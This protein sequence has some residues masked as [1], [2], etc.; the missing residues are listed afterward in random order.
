[1][2]TLRQTKLFCLS[3]SDNYCIRSILEI[4]CTVLYKR[5]FYDTNCFSHF[6]VP[7][8]LIRGSSLHLQLKV[9]AL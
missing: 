8:Q 5:A 3:V 4:S 1:M 6:R 2:I 9:L 7:V